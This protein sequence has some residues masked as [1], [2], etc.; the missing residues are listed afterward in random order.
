MLMFSQMFAQLLLTS[1]VLATLVVV[2]AGALGF[3]S[4]VGG[5]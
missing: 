3:A 2:G 4:R 1:G 5:R